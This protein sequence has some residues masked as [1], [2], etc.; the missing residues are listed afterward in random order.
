MGLAVRPFHGTVVLGKLLIGVSLVING[1]L[2][3]VDTLLVK[4]KTALLH[5]LE[6]PNLGSLHFCRIKVALSHSLLVLALKLLEACA[7]LLNLVDDTLAHP[8]STFHKLLLFS[9]L[10]SSHILQMI[11]LSSQHLNLRL[12]LALLALH[13]SHDL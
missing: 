2:K 12:H 11:N 6:E 4:L 5:G 9:H 13:L 10:L 8:D 7:S 3:H 1:C